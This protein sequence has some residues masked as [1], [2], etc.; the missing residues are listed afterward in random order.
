MKYSTI[1]LII[2]DIPIS[3]KLCLTD[4]MVALHGYEMPPVPKLFNSASVVLADWQSR[5]MVTVWTH[6]CIFL[7]LSSGLRSSPPIRI[8]DGWAARSVV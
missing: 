4:D 7:M 8:L 2:E 3:E 6:L 5:I 1:A